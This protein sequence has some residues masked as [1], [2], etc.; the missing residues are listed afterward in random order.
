MRPCTSNS[1]ILRWVGL[2]LVG[3]SHELMAQKIKTFLPC[4]TSTPTSSLLFSSLITLHIENTLPSVCLSSK[5]H[6]NWYKCKRHSRCGVA[7]CS[8][9]SVYNDKSN[10]SKRSARNVFKSHS[11]PSHELMAQKIKKLFYR[12][13]LQQQTLLFSSLLFSS[14]LITLHIEN[15]LPSVL[16]FIKSAPK[17]VQ[18]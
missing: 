10:L 9:F 3:P 13:Q 1:I 17:L 18:M 11:C 12:A 2:T 14:P 5:V 8:L 4:T 15:R 16:S 7:M 6:L